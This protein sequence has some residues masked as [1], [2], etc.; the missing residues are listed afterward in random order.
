MGN[1]RKT[2]RERTSKDPRTKKSRKK[3]ANKSTTATTKTYDEVSSTLQLPLMKLKLKLVV[4][5]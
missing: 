4:Q 3:G 2:I 5:I 1:K